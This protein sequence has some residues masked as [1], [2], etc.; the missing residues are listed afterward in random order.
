MKFAY[1]KKRSLQPAFI[2][3]KVTVRE[4]RPL[5]SV[6]VPELPPAAIPTPKVIQAPTTEAAPLPE[7]RKVP[8]I[9]A[10]PPD[11][12]PAEAVSPESTQPEPR[13]SAF[14]KNEGAGREW[15]PVD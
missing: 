1:V 4:P 3:R 8:Q 11:V 14:K 15:K 13:K 9:V 7:V 2:E 6:V 10:A 5:P 12:V